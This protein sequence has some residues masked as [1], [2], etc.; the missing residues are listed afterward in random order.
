[1]K[2]EKE[3]LNKWLNTFKKVWIEK[4]LDQV[5]KIFFKIENYYKAN[6]LLLLRQ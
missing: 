1:M 3:F 2:V 6:H 4:D 5:K